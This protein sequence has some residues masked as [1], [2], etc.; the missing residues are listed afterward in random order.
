MSFSGKPVSPTWTYL[1]V[2]ASKGS[3]VIHLETPVMWNVGDV[4][5]IASTGD[6]KTNN[7]NEKRKIYSIS[8]GRRT[9]TLTEPLESDHAS[10]HEMFDGRLVRMRAEVGLLTRN[11]IIRGNDDTQWHDEIQTCDIEYKS[12]TLFSIT[13]DF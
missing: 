3:N 12:G 1:S 4:I 2:T 13:L 9:L 8:N 10:V 6:S 11:I 5:V 7:D